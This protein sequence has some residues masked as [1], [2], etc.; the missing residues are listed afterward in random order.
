V[1][2]V[3]TFDPYHGGHECQVCGQVFWGA[4]SSRCPNT[5]WSQRFQPRYHTP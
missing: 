4:K 3:V 1:K 2:K 5:Y